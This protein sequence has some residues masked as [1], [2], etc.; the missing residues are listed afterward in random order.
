MLTLNSADLDGLLALFLFPFVRIAAWLFFDPLLGNRAAPAS[1][2]LVLAVVLTVAVAPILP[3]PQQ[4]QLMSGDGLLVLLQQIAIGS[5]L[6]FSL[7]IVF[8]AVEYA[9]QIMGLQMGL[10][11]AT[12]FDPI[13]GAQT[14]VI[15]QFLVLSSA[16]I[17]FAFNGHHVVIDALAQSFIDIPVG[18]SLG[19]AGFFGL[20]QW[21]GALFMTGLHIALPVTAAL[22]ATNLTIG[23][24][25][26]AAPQLNI[27]AVGFPLTLG[28]G[29]LVL[30]FTLVYLPASLEN[31]WGQALWTATRAMGGVAGQ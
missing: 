8:A 26:R 14:P 6:G 7:R 20:V 31:L 17:L 3:N 18:A 4:L 28:A 23:M 21:G 1:T 27:F 10:S 30:Y 2:R 5:A 13:N 25:T 15:S 12:L 16:L 29:F 22:L 24:M 9:G 11:F 19:A